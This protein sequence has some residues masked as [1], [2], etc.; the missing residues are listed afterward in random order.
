MQ[1]LRTLFWVVVA[2]IA[3]IFAAN[4]WTSVEV[5][6]WGGIVVDAKLPILMLIAFLIGVVPS[7]LIYQATRWRLRRRLESAERS[8]AELRPAVAAQSSA[9]A[10][11]T[12]EPLTPVQ[13]LTP[14]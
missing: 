13:P 2:A 14:S 1:F 11:P 12:S 3:V 8:L 10:L 4:N 5:N 6:M 7:F 9:N